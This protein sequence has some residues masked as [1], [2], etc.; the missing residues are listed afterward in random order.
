MPWWKWCEFK[1]RCDKRW[2][3]RIVLRILSWYSRLVKISRPLVTII[4][5]SKTLNIFCLQGQISDPFEWKATMLSN[6]LP[7][8][9]VEILDN[10]W[11][12]MIFKYEQGYQF[13]SDPR[14]KHC[15][16]HNG[17]KG[18]LLS[19]KELLL[20]MSQIGQNSASVSRPNLS[21]TKLLAQ[22]VD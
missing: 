5:N 2:V 9:F 12:R 6:N 21:F 7:R 4:L 20:V 17:P 1:Q 15:Q 14:Y 13:T 8:S 18:C 11:I 3:E 19:P 22:N 10:H 16:R